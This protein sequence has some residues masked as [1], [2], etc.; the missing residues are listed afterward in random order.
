VQARLVQRLQAIAAEQPR[1]HAFG[2]SDRVA[3]LMAASDVLVT[4]PGPGSVAEALHQRI[5][6]VTIANSWTVPQ[7]RFNARYLAEKGLGFVERRWRD[8]PER[9]HRLAGDPLERRAIMER[10]AA[11]PENRAVFET[12][13]LL[14]A[15][16]IRQPARQQD[17][18]AVV[19]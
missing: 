11:L 7:E 12:L 10:Q 16:M 5:P 9:V 18:P 14:E 19:A 6:V 4:K 8:L 17:Q 2:F 15:L 3:D 13:D 1:L